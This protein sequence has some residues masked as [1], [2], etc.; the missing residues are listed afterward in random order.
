MRADPMKAYRWVVSWDGAY[1]GLRV[2]TPGGFPA[3]RLAAASGAADVDLTAT[4]KLNEYVAN[5]GIRRAGGLSDRGEKASPDTSIDSLFPRGARH[6]LSA[7][8][9]LLSWLGV[10]IPMHMSPVTSHPSPSGRDR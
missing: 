6:G 10:T 7:T 4:A 2:R 5:D 9:G 1:G 8:A 3:V